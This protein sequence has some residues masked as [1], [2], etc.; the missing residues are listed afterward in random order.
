MCLLNVIDN[1]HRDIYLAGALK[2][3]VFG[4]TLDELAGL[5][6]GA[7]QSGASCP[8]L[9]DALLYAHE[10]E[11]NPKLTRFLTWLEEMRAFA[12]TKPVDK[13]L[14]HVYAT[15]SLLSDAYNRAAQSGQG[16]RANL[17]M[18]YEH[19]RRF[20]AGSF[21]G[22]YNFILYVEQ[23]MS[24]EAKV[25][26]AK[27]QSEAVSAVTRMRRRLRTPWRLTSCPARL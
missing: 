14:W 9:Y 12:K 2:S 24:A 22:L 19:A 13:L 6:R 4:L 21:K 17:M 3:P 23:I 5:R 20:E 1:P 18:L 10:K 15:T 27:T 7:D 26:E 16:R 8:S 25:E 11:H